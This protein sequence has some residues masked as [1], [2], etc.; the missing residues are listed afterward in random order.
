M[1]NHFFKKNK[2]M[3]QIRVSKIYFACVVLFSTCLIISNVVEQKLI[4][5]WGIPATAG[6][7]IFPI[8][9]IIN[10]LVAEVWGYNKAKMM[11]WLGFAMNALAVVFF[12]LA[13][14]L[15]ASPS[16]EHQEAFEQILGN[17]TARIS[18]A[19][20]VAFVCGSLLNAYV[21]SRM[22]L[23]HKGKKFSLRAVVSTL[24]G[25]TADSTVFFTLAFVGVIPHKELITLIAVQITL[26]T[27]YE[28]LFLPLTSRI[29][30]YVKQKEQ[31]DVFDHDVDYKIF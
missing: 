25:E 31:I 26:K 7:M 6:L 11:I 15:P 18:L 1:L 4:S 16:F 24:F 2:N 3:S 21:M 23:R 10:D 28:I 13:I 9:Y 14:L 19:S 30:R 27:L 20:F 5:L 17:S 29:V 8:S 12:R 22:K